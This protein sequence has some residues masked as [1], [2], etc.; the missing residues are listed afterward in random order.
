[1]TE[2]LRPGP[3][4]TSG[5]QPID[6]GT[7]ALLA[8]S[9]PGAARSDAADA[10]RF[11]NEIRALQGALTTAGAFA[12]NDAHVRSVYNQ[13]VQDAAKSW[14][15]AAQSGAISWKQAAEEA[16]LLRNT[17]MDA[18]RTRTSPVGRA[19]A[20]AMKAQGKT[21]NTLV[22]EKTV[23]IFGSGAN[24]NRLNAAQ[25][26]QVYAA[27]VESAGKANPKV[28]ATMAR[29]GN[30]GRALLFLSIAISVYNVA[31]A[32]NK[33]AAAGKEVAVTGASIAGGAAGGALAGLACGPGAPACVAVGAFVGGA[34]A[35][36]GV[37]ALW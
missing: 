28:N 21:M 22:A 3:L 4:G 30:A 20:Q 6:F 7:R 33:V 35:A 17:I 31:V 8:H 26:N 32:D 1:M 10:A 16:S 24:F 36:F 11:E 23:K 29:M 12:A 34:L 18:L 9:P 2:F 37:S 5:F 27:V 15:S 19:S 14:R 13:R 25:Q